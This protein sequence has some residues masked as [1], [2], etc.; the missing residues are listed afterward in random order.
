MV[1]PGLSLSAETDDT[2]A[3]RKLVLNAITGIASCAS[4]PAERAERIARA[5]TTASTR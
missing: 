4:L 1:R 5:L 3:L 2:Q